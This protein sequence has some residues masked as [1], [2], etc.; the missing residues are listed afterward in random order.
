MLTEAQIDEF[1]TNG[2]LR[3]DGA[4]SEDV[5]REARDILWRSCRCD[6]ERPDTWTQPV[7]RLGEHSEPSFRAAAES[8]AL[9]EAFDQLV[10]VGRWQR[11]VSVGSFVIRFPSEGDPGDTGWH[12]DMS[13]GFDQ[14]N[15]M[16]WRANITSQG[17]ALLL[18]FLFSD[19]GEDDAP[20]RVRL[21]S[22]LDIA[23]RLAPAGQEGVTLG[24]LAATGFAES[25]HRTE[26]LAVGGAGTVYICHP[27]IVHSAQPHRG[28]RP[29]FM[30]QPPLL[31][32]APL[33]LDGPNVDH[34]P[35]ERSIRLALGS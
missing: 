5:A 30:A 29:R 16:N 17:R 18:L 6:P 13:Y 14:A 19:V 21:G 12:V 15:F 35:L 28:R 31:P 27:F 7:V 24:E 33:R 9:S 34:T 26:V 22:H 23:R 2:L 1:I 4:F 25:A 32:T 8:P 20:T 11:R 3:I 10:G